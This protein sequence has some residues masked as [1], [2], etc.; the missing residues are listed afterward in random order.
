MFDPLTQRRGNADHHCIAGGDGLAAGNDDHL[1]LLGSTGV[2][3]GEVEQQLVDVDIAGEIGGVELSLRCVD[4]LAGFVP[5]G[6]LLTVD[7][8]NRGLLHE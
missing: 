2:T 8:P 1:V 7:H 3:G 4:G 5:G 6:L